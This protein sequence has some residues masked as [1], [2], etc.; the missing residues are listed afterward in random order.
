MDRGLNSELK[1]KHVLLRRLGLMEEGGAMMDELLAKYACL[2]ERPLVEDMVRAFVD[3][4][5]WSVP[6][7][8]GAGGDTLHAMP[9]LVE[10]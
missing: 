10:A 7:T 4:Y 6:G 5:G 3:F 8:E 2:F 1:A 9:R